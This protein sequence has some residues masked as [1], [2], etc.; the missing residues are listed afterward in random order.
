MAIGYHIYWTPGG[1]PGGQILSKKSKNHDFLISG[2]SKNGNFLDKK[3]DYH[4]FLTPRG[5]P[6]RGAPRGVPQGGFAPGQNQVVFGIKNPDFWHFGPPKGGSGPQKGGLKTPFLGVR[7]PARNQPLLRPPFFLQVGKLLTFFSKNRDFFSPCLG[8]RKYRCF[9]SH[10]FEK[11]HF[12]QK[13]SARPGPKSLFM[14]KKRLKT[15]KN[16]KKTGFF[17]FLGVQISLFLGCDFSGCPKLL[18]KK[19]K[20]CSFF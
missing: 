17:A 11:T 1:S 14:P 10:W 7:T 2:G 15:Q 3:S 19:N 20:M 6:P 13:S 9:V 5:G 16:D 8:H 4:F 12:C 18:K